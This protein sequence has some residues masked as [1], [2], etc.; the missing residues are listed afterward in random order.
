MTAH[1]WDMIAT[2]HHAPTGPPPA[3]TAFVVFGCS[4]CRR[5]RFFPSLNHELTTPSFRDA[6]SEMLTAAGYDDEV[7]NHDE[8][9]TPC[10]VSPQ[11]S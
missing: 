4:R 7:S 11:D 5:V 9:G 8:N 3:H 2:L 1:A 10:P 6:L